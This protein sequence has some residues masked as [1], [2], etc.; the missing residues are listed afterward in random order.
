MASQRSSGPLTV[1]FLVVLIDMIGFTLVIPFL[2][3]FI[4]D[5]ATND[6]FTDVGARDR[7]VGIVLASYTLGQFLLTPVLGAVSDSYGRRPVLILG[8]LSN[9]V[10]LIA[11]GLATSL[12]MALLARFLAGAGNGNIA[13]AKAYIGDISSREELPGRMGMIGASFGLGFMIGP[14]LGGI[15]TDPAASFG[16]PFETQWW[17][18]HPYFLP[19]LFASLL[20][21]V[22]LALAIRLLPESLPADKRTRQEGPKEI[23]RL[24]TNLNSIMTMPAPVRG[25][26]YTNSAFLLAFTMMH[27]TFILFTA[28]PV[29]DGGLGYDERMNG[30][31]FAYVGL[32]GV[33][34]QGGLIRKLSERYEAGSL[35]AIGIILTALGLGSIPYL[36]PTPLVIGLLVMTLIAAG[37]G[38]FQPTQSTMLT[39][40][41]RAQGL[42][43][44]S[45]MGVQ[46]GF[47]ALSRIVGPILAA[48]IWSE[49]VDGTG[50]WSYHTVF[51]VAGAIAILAFIIY[52]IPSKQGGIDHA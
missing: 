6:G 14:M 43:L 1:L 27:A 17:I 13:V 52:R 22:S 18:D 25:L 49:T 33:I 26:V 38:L 40:E 39:Q 29:A 5:L 45:V 12:W 48:V 4:Q 32:V 51:R 44:G 9:T 23:G 7:W 24:L 20:S 30:Y 3:Y 47:G 11:F 35:M 50:V 15:L 42:D 28:M 8:L 10:F 46:E 2:T 19:C 31:I 34:V 37:N 21:S 16:G 36:K 41:S